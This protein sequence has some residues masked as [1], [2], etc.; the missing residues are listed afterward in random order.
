MII[1]MLTPNTFVEI[2]DNPPE[3][4]TLKGK[5][6]RG[7]QTFHVYT[8]VAD[9]DNS[10]ISALLSSLVSNGARQAAQR[11]YNPYAIFD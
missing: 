6:V 3:Y 1:L 2:R 9:F 8:F 5:F 11:D 7:A 10:E 4:W